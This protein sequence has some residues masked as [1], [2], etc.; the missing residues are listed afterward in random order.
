MHSFTVSLYKIT[1]EKRVTSLWTRLADITLVTVSDGTDQN[2]TPPE[3][4]MRKT[5]GH[6]LNVHVKDA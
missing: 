2:H 4:A 1:K 3:D 6:F 5:Q